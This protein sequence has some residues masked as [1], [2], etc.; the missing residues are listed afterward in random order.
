MRTLTG[1]AIS[2]AVAAVFGLAVMSIQPAAA[3]YRHRNDAA[4]L[5]A[6]ATIFGSV[7]AI[8]A[9]E[10]YRNRYESAYPHGAVRPGPGF[11]S[12]GHWRHHHH[13]HYR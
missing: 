4:A 10:Q 12:H 13:H 9:A 5:A 3:G 7:A 1:R 6:F 8:I 2:T 11:G